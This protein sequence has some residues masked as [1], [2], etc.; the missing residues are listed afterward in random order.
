M[1][2]PGPGA[3][4]RASRVCDRF[5]FAV[6]ARHERGRGPRGVLAG[7][8]AWGERCDAHSRVAVAVSGAGC[9]GG[10]E[11]GG[12]SGG[13]DALAGDLAVVGECGEGLVEL[14]GGGVAV[15]QVA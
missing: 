9:C 13:E 15:Q 1:K 4:G 3:C 8:G 12:A 5:A 11:L 14:G 6:I 2:A 7:E 10:P